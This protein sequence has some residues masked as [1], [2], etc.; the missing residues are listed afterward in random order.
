MR[1][2]RSPNPDL[3]PTECITSPYPSPTFF[4]TVGA[5]VLDVTNNI[6]SR[7]REESVSESEE[8]RGGEN[9][10]QVGRTH[11]Q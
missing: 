6:Q 10:V 9:T 7:R 5:D 4:P 1:K 2:E 3:Y 8:D 11:V